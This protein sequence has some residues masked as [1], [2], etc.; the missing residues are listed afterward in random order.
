M[1]YV[2]LSL[3]PAKETTRERKVSI[4]SL[5]DSWG[6]MDDKMLEAAL[7]KF[8][9]DWGGKGSAPYHHFSTSIRASTAMTS[10]SSANR[11]LMSI[12]LISVAKRRRVERRTMISA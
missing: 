11:G 6:D 9:K 3:K 12:S 10:F 7:A 2:L 5:V 8:H 1:I 4:E